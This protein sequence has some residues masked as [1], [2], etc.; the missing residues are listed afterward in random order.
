MKKTVILLMM[1]VSFGATSQ[2]EK[3][4][5]FDANMGT[6]LGGATSTMATVGAGFHADGGIGYMFNNWIG[7]EGH[8]GFNTFN[9]VSVADNGIVDK[10]YLYNTSLQGVV[11]LSQLIGFGTE[12]FDL[13]LHTGFG[14]S[15]FANPGFKSAYK[16]N[17]EFGDRFFKGNDE[18]VNITFGLTPRFHIN[19]KISINLD[20]S[21]FVL[22]GQ[23]H[24][25]D[26]EI[27]NTFLEGTTGITN[28]AVGISYRL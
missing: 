21:Y 16:E 20:A 19:E 4:L 26:R 8:L 11:V 7:I 10:S 27:G 24:S 6:R 2:T 5:F 23:D 28:L 9:A 18:A 3:G 25:L 22:F 17:N 13:N 12:K 14:F 1:F 15:T